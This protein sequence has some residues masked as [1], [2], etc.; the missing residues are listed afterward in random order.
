M[1]DNVNGMRVNACGI[2][3]RLRDAGYWSDED[4]EA[5]TD[6]IERMTEREFDRWAQMLRLG[7]GVIKAG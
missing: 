2:V 6:R 4:A 7:A 5:I 1:P 3:W